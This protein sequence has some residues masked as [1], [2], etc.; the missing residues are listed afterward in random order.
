M[1]TWKNIEMELGRS[2]LQTKPGGGEE[3]WTD[4][5]ARAR[6][7]VQEKPSRSAT[8]FIW[9]SLAGGSALAILLAVFWTPEA[10]A[11]IR[12]TSLEAEA[13]HTAAMILNVASE[14]GAGQGAIVWISGLQEETP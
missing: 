13:P 5:K 14:N 10:Q 6:L 11:T 4:F 7:T 9:A 3:F 2:S 12:V 1:S 8:P